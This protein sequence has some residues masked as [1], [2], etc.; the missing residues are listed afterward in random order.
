M[1]LQ[2]SLLSSTKIRGKENYLI[3]IEF[4]A[5]ENHF[6]SLITFFFHFV[7]PKFLD[8][9]CERLEKEEILKKELRSVRSKVRTTASAFWK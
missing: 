7:E 6:H 9:F 5:N 2:K 8:V 3:Q 1:L 4:V